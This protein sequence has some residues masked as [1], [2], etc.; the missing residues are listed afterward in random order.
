MALPT[1]EMWTKNE[2]HPRIAAVQRGYA[3][4]HVQLV[5]EG[6]RDEHDDGEIHRAR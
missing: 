1:T 5:V 6:D 2:R 3:E 4:L